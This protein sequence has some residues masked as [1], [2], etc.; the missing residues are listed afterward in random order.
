MG[1]L[2]R[3]AVHAMRSTGGGTSLLSD[4]IFTPP[5]LVTHTGVVGNYMGKTPGYFGPMVWAGKW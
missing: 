5:Q 4:E 2:Q 1:S 3:L